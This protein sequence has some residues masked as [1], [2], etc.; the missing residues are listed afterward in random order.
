MGEPMV[1][2]SGHEGKDRVC[3]NCRHNT[4][5][6]QKTYIDCNCDIDGH[7]IGYVQGF[8]SWCRRWAKER[9]DDELK[10]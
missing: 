3:C 5:I 9:T 8:D 2:Y 10:K 4:R 6:A 1:I 7:R